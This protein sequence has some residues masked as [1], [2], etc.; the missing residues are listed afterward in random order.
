MVAVATLPE[1]WGWPA[2]SRKSHYFQE[3]E[4]ISVC[5]KWMFT[6]QRERDSFESSDDCASCRRWVKRHRPDDQTRGL[7]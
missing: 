6:G 3:G 7:I 5:G 4:A 2:N 1:G